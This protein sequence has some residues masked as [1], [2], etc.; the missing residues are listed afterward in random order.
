MPVDGIAVCPGPNYVLCMVLGEPSTFYTFQAK[1]G[2]TL[3]SEGEVTTNP[4]GLGYM[5]TGYSNGTGDTLTITFHIDG[6]QFSVDMDQ[7]AP[8]PPQPEE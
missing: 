1:V 5:D 3:I 8:E 4:S 2:D 6:Q 7:V